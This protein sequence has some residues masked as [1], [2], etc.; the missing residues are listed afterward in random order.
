MSSLCQNH[1]I[2]CFTDVVSPG[3]CRV[4]PWQDEPA[5]WHRADPV[6]HQDLESVIQQSRCSLP[7]HAHTANIITASPSDGL[8]MEIV[9]KRRLT[10]EL[11]TTYLPSFLLVLMC[12]AT[13]FF[14][15]IYFEA[16]VTVNLS[17][18]LVT[19]TLFIRSPETDY[20][21]C[22][23]WDIFL[24]FYSSVMAKLPATS[25][26][27]MVD[28]WLIFTQLYPFLEV[29]LYTL[30]ELYNDEDYTNHHGFKKDV[31]DEQKQGVDHVFN[32][33]VF[34]W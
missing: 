24:S 9:F 32:K 2:L 18:L 23:D 13:S 19:T 1:I 25:Y 7:T 10:N 11:L 5:D 16:A 4:G 12:Y 31:P 8:K 15:P 34:S 6:L 28:I 14:K 26:V 30:I 3:E 27:R 29:V 21:L 17:I 20:C 22:W 33:S